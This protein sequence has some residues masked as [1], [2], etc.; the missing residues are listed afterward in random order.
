MRFATPSLLMFA[1]VTA[2]G[3]AHA[4]AALDEGTPKPTTEATARP[5]T[6]DLADQVEYGVDIRL[7]K[8][9]LPASLMGLFVQRAA[10]GADNTG[11]GFDLVRRRGNLELQLGFEYEHIN[12][13]EGVWIDNGNDVT[14]GDTID[15]ILSPDHAG[16]NF[17]W[18]TVE[19]TFL[20]HAPINK[21]VAIRY[22]GGAGLGILSGSVK[23]WDIQ[24]AAGA[25]NTNVDPYCIPPQY[26]G[27]SGQ[28]GTGTA[29]SDNGGAPETAPVAYNLPP[30]FPVINAI[31]G[32]QIKPTNKSVIN[33]EGGIRTLPFFGISAGYFF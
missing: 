16:S 25:T 1:I 24:C 21:Y 29:L 26:K 22:G 14:K 27:A 2:S 10:G 18:Y 12:I 5:D 7:R 31:I 20:N 6:P 19:F 4:Q 3:S 13:A 30:V 23:R 15:Y 17:G 11:V 9:Y 8:V 33:I 28:Q 32:I